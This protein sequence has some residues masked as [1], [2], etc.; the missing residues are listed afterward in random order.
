VLE[1]SASIEPAQTSVTDPVSMTLTLTNRTAWPLVVN[2]RLLLNHPFAPERAREV[3][4]E[5]DGPPSY[6]QAGGFRI[7]AGAPSP[8]HF[9]ELAPGES[10]SKEYELTRYYS[11]SVPGRYSIRG[12][13]ANTSPGPSPDRPAWIGTIV[14]NSIEIERLPPA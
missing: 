3:F 11:L 7:R 14:S 5:I 13:Y 2:R 12:T 4:L 9:V 6:R 10:V 8:E 1:L